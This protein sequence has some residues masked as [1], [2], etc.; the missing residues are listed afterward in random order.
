MLRKLP[1]QEEE[2]LQRIKAFL[3]QQIILIAR[4]KEDTHIQQYHALQSLS[5]LVSGLLYNEGANIELSCLSALHYDFKC[6]NIN[7]IC[8]GP[9]K[10]I[11]RPLG[12][13][14][15]KEFPDFIV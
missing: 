3:L 2:M 4:K 10:D 14:E 9:L 15:R 11:L 5:D 6:H 13:M 8:I 1:K 7:T 12:A